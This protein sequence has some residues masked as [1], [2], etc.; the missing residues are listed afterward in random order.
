MGF[1]VFKKWGKIN[2]PSIVLSQYISTK[3]YN[4]KNKLYTHMIHTKVNLQ[5]RAIKS[6]FGIFKYNS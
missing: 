2:I 1:V 6:Y 3:N 4:R 5:H